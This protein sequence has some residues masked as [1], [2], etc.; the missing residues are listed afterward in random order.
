MITF[1]KGNY[2][3]FPEIFKLYE[4]TIAHME[5]QSLTQWKWGVYPNTKIITDDLSNGYSFLLFDDETLIG[6]FALNQEEAPE[7]REV[8]WMYGTRP[9]VMHRFVIDPDYQNRGI[10]LQAMELMKD[11][12]RE[13]GYDC[14]RLDTYSQNTAALKLYEKAGFRKSGQVFF[15]EKEEPFICFET[16]LTSNCSI[17]PIPMVPAYRHGEQTPWGGNQLKSLYQK[18]TPDNQ[19]GESLE[20]SAIPGLVS[21]SLQGEGLDELL[22]LHKEEIQGKKIQGP[23]PLLLKLLDAKQPLSVQVH[24]DDSYAHQYENGKFGK[25]EAWLILACE[26]GAKLVYGVKEGTTKEALLK[27][28][29][30]GKAVETLLRQVEVAPGDVCFIPAGC[31]HAIGEGIV[32]YE[33]QQSSDVTYRFYDWDR[34]DEKGN[35]RELHLE[36]AIAVTDVGLQ[37]NP[38]ATKNIKDPIATLLENPVFTMEKLTLEEGAS[39][40]LQKDL[41]RFRILTSLTKATLTTLASHLSLNPGDSVLIPASCPDFTLKGE[42]SIILSMPTL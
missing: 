23:F 13:T 31:V 10:G 7:Y 26:P 28:S 15:R 8:P 21:H 16:P 17:L 18:N 4:K 40:T 34:T 1:D 25:T 12:A 5:S 41:N 20:V 35:K 19:T 33:I 37:L 24:P 39:L 29:K 38:I 36:K 11:L 27:A 9:I 30:Q 42:G 22:S 14:L 32:L 2:W 3:Q 6:A